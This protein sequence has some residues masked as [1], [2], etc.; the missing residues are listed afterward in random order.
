MKIIEYAPVRGL[1][2]VS[3][4]VLYF[5]M[6]VRAYSGRFCVIQILHELRKYMKNVTNEGF[7]LFLFTFRVWKY[8][9][10]VPC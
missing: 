6:Y 3:K 4:Q 1:Y 7:F 10:E 2:N 5:S 9:V 8:L